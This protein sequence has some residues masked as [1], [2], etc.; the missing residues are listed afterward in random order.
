MNLK[1]M[2]KHIS[3]HDWLVGRIG[4]K[5]RGVMA[6]HAPCFFCLGVGSHC[7]HGW[8]SHCSRLSSLWMNLKDMDKCVHLTLTYDTRTAY[9]EMFFLFGLFMV[10]G[11][12]GYHGSH[13]SRFQT[14][15]F[16]VSMASSGR[17]QPHCSCC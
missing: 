17:V 7:Y 13:G 5:T 3:T 2:D 15:D 12:V 10:F 11:S 6:W 8:H 16:P 9:S 14:V 4:Q 1:D